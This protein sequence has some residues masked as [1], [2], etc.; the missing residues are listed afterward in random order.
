[1][2]KRKK[3]VRKSIDNGMPIAYL[4]LKHTDKNFEF[5]EWHWF[6]VNGY[7]ERNGRFFYQGCHI[8]QSTLA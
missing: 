5:F 6:L 3:E 4:M 7:E 2:R 8:R 1:M